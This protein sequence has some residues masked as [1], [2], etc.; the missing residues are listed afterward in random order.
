MKTTFTNNHLEVNMKNLT[1]LSAIIASV[2]S[3]NLIIAEDNSTQ[4]NP[5]IQIELTA[6]MKSDLVLASSLMVIDIKDELTDKQSLSVKSNEF[7]VSEF[8]KSATSVARI[9]LSSAQLTS[10]SE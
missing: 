5:M 4:L 6:N 8:K 2:M 3:T 7:I 10:I 9:D 1:I